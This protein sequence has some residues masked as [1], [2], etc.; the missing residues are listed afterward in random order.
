MTTKT[1]TKVSTPEPAVVRQPVISTEEPSTALAPVTPA[2]VVAEQRPGF[3]SLAAALAA[4]QGAGKAVAKDGHNRFHGYRYAT[5]DSIIAAGRELLSEHGLAL[6]PTQSQVDGWERSGENRFELK[7]GW[8][9]CHTSG[10]SIDCYVAWPI[11]LEKGRPL[12][13][14]TAIA[15][16]SSL[17]YLLR[18]LLLLPR[19]DESDLNAQSP[20]TAT[21]TPAPAPTP[22]PAPAPA[23]APAAATP[24]PPVLPS[25]SDPLGPMR[26]EQANTIAALMQTLHVSDESMASRLVQSG[27]PGDW[28]RLNQSQA[29]GIIERMRTAALA[30]QQEKVRT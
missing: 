6:I 7:R 9:L 18:D 29:A 4:A 19:G 24:P 17:A 2:P 15:D 27:M 25:G 12:D 8:K 14:A 28:R 22:T 10:E 3:A 23:P 21:S 11:V 26:E 30:A 20:A 5:A 1:R 16:T 13:K